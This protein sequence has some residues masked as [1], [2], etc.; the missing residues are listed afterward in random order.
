MASNLEIDLQDE[1]IDIEKLREAVKWRVQE[2]KELLD[3]IQTGADQFPSDYNNRERIKK[4][5]IDLA[6]VHTTLQE[7]C[8]KLY[9]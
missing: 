1:D 4:S 6:T 3:S 8:Q 5:I 9:D 7:T 2:I